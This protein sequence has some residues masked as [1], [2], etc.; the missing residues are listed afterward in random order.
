MLIRKPVE[1][2]FEAIVNPDITTKFWFSK[3]SGRLET[4]D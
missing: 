2:V 1:E 4:G 3:G